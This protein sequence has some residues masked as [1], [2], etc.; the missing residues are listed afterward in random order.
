MTQMTATAYQ[1]PKLNAPVRVLRT[2]EQGGTKLAVVETL[3]GGV[4]AWSVVGY[5]FITPLKNLRDI[6]EQAPV[7][8]KPVTVAPEAPAEPVAESVPETTD[9]EL[10]TLENQ[11]AEL[12]ER[13]VANFDRPT[14]GRGKQGLRRT[15]AAIRRGAQMVKQYRQLESAIASRR[16]VLGIQS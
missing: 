5:Q 8:P 15:D 1:S 7:A 2:T 14:G 12:S 3:P 9:P 16:A 13:I 6:R 10:A 4:G 11:L